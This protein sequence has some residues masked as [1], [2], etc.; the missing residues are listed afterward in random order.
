MAQVIDVLIR[1]WHNN[2]NDI[3]IDFHSITLI[4]RAGSPKKRYGDSCSILWKQIYRVSKKP[5]PNTFYITPTILVQCQHILICEKSPYN[6]DLATRVI[7]Q[8]ILI[9]KNQQLTQI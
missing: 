3:Y 6:Q 8:K 9:T 4:C 5:D 7:L 2:N 1:F